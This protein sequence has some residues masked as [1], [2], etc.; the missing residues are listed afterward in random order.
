M[1]LR[2]TLARSHWKNGKPI[3]GNASFM[4]HG[5]HKM[6]NRRTD[7][8]SQWQDK[9]PVIG[10]MRYDMNNPRRPDWYVEPTTSRPDPYATEIYANEMYPRKGMNFASFWW[11]NMQNSMKQQGLIQRHEA[12]FAW[13]TSMIIGFYILSKTYDWSPPPHHTHEEHVRQ[14]ALQN[15]TRW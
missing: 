3:I 6:V 8:G 14:V 15:I 5:N 1:A 7:F 4:D 11:E 9:I 10:K 13:V 12:N 2:F